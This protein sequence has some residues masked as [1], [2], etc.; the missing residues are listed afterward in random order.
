MP[1]PLPAVGGPDLV[2]GAI[3]FTYTWNPLCGQPGNFASL[4]G[5]TVTMTVVQPDTDYRAVFGMTVSGDGT[6]ASYTTQHVGDF[7]TAGQYE[8][9]FTVSDGSTLLLQTPFVIRLV[10]AAI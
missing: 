4:S 8:V 1:Q 7:P 9:Q 5:L 3:G 6:T 10:A 2:A